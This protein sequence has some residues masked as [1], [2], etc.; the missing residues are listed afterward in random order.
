MGFAVFAL[1]PRA[2]KNQDK[3]KNFA[4]RF[5]CPAVAWQKNYTLQL[6]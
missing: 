2:N 1:L 6:F 4:Y 5:F 3:L